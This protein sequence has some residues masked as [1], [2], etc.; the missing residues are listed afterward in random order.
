M[1]KL[2]VLRQNLKIAQNFKPMSEPEMRALEARTK[3]AAGD[4]RFEL[5]KVSLRYDNPQARMAHGF[6]IDKEQEEVQEMLQAVDNDGHPFP[7]LSQ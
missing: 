5:Y 7:P 3:E 1:D 6:P 4:A 2:E